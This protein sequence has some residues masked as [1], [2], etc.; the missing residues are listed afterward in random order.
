MGHLKRI[1]HIP[2]K[3]ALIT[4]I[5][6]TKYAKESPGFGVGINYI[7][8]GNKSAVGFITGVYGFTSLRITK[9]DSTLKFKIGF[10]GAY[11]EK[12]FNP[13]TNNKNN[14]IGSHFNSNVI[15]HLKKDF[16]FDKHALYISGGLTHFSNGSGQAPNLGLNFVSLNIGYSIYAEKNKAVIPQINPSTLKPKWSYG[17][18]FKYGFRENF[19]YKYKKYG[20]ST[21]NIY[22]IYNK[23]DK[24]N[25]IGGLDLTLNPSIQFYNTSFSAFQGGL[26]VGKEWVLNQLILGIDIGGYLY[27]EFK[28]DGIS[29]QRLNINYYVTP[30]IKTTLSLRTHWTVAQAFQIGIAYEIKKT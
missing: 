5:S 27:D 8:S 9:R 6:Y 2:Q 25:Y 24:R 23:N 7:N 30:Q 13:N 16:L 26:F 17:I 22:A 21:L 14:A 11:I 1:N 10:G 3:K 29:F 19:Q 15:F 18:G 28:D 12:I 20:I 4:D